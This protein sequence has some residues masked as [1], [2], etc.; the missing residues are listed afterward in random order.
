MFSSDRSIRDYQQPSGSKTL[1]TAYG[2]SARLNRPPLPQVSRRYIN[3]KATGGD[4]AGDAAKA[5]GGDARSAKSRS[6]AAVP[7]PKCCQ[8]ARAASQHRRQR[9][10][11]SGISYGKGQKSFTGR[12]AAARNLTLPPPP[13][14]PPNGYH[15]CCLAR[16]KNS[17]CAG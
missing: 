17:G 4:S 9:W 10:S 14:T 16:G 5:A 1:R 2:S 12:I 7:V 3:A 11:T 15:H 13:V 6:W 8:Q